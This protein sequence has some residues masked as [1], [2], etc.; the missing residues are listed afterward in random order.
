MLNSLTDLIQ[1][2]FRLF[3]WWVFVAPWEEAV[4]VRAGKWVR[5]LGAGTHLKIPILDRI[6]LQTTRRRV[7]NMP[8][9]SLTTKDGHAVTLSAVLGYRIADLTKLYQTLYHAEDT[10]KNLALAA[11]AEYVATHDRADCT[12]AAIQGF[13]TG[14]MALERYGLADPEVLI[15][16]FVFA[17]VYRIINDSLSWGN[18]DGLSLAT[19]V[20]SGPPS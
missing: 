2:F 1:K 7:T 10:I 19:P 15:T 18:G 16:S 11:N 17:R 6:Y 3:I 20:V 12:P 9:Q 4:R 13:S 14:K 8:T 5:K